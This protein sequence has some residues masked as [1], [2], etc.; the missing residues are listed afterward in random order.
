MRACGSQE[1]PA[2][3]CNLIDIIHTE[4]YNTTAV[5]RRHALYHY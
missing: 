4:Y 3:M 2:V 1:R 5:R